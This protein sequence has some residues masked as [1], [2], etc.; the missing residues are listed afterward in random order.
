MQFDDATAKQWWGFPRVSCEAW[1]NQGTSCGFPY[2][3]PHTRTWVAPR[4]GNP[5]RPIFFVPRTLGR[6]WGTRR[7]TATC[8]ETPGMALGTVQGGMSA[9]PL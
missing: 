3:K 5:G 9:I 8:F 7:G 4:A 1:W 6:T 2:R